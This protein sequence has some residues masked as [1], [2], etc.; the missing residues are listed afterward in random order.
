[1]LALTAYCLLGMVVSPSNTMKSE[2]YSGIRSV[3]SVISV[4]DST[5]GGVEPSQEGNKSASPWSQWRTSR[6]ITGARP[7]SSRAQ[8]IYFTGTQS[9]TLSPSDI[10]GKSWQMT[11]NLSLMWKPLNGIGLKLRS[12]NNEDHIARRTGETE[13][14]Y[15]HLGE[16]M[17]LNHTNYHVSN[18]SSKDWP[19]WR[20]PTLI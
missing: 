8:L 3:S 12:F 20:P 2:Y 5:Q 9:I 16:E 13:P 19:F 1:M 17:R 4:N 11:W 15:H 14:T 7:G 6:Q 10:A 18:P